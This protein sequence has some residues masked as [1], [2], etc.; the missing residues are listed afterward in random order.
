VASAS[1]SVATGRFTPPRLVLDP[2]PTGMSSSTAASPQ[3]GSAGTGPSLPSGPVTAL[4]SLMREVVLTG[5]GT[6]LRTVPGAP[7]QG[8]TGT[9]E[10]GTGNPPATHAWFTGYQGDIA[11]AVVVEGGGFGAKAAAPL[12]AAFL[13]SLNS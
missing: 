3:A 10:F 12:A 4:R 1:A 11:F 9:A 8:K 5:T 13:T 7:V 6:A 2:A